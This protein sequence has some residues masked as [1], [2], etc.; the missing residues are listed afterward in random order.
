MSNLRRL[1][2]ACTFGLLLTITASADSLVLDPPGDFIPTYAGPQGGDLDVLSAQVTFTGT[3]FLFAGR[4]NAAIGTTPGTLY[5]F[6]ID[7][8]AGTPRFGV[9]NTGSATYDA[10]G[11]LFDS[12]VTVRPDGTGTVTLLVPLPPAATQLA[13]GSVTITG[14]SFLAR[15]PV[16][17]LPSLGF[18][19]SQFTWNLWPRL[20]AGNNNQ[21]SDFAPNNSNA[22][23]ATPE[24]ATVL[25]I[26]TGLVGIAAKLR[27]RRKSE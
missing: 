8:G 6:G 23:V 26:S 22:P 27:R 20:G 15:V 9:I 3:E 10:T 12:V 21:I 1:F 13:P 4:V 11:V 2:L 5:V 7:R 16:A 25:L 19:P 24:P 14:D 17:L 18:A